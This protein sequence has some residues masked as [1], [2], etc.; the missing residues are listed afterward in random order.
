MADVFTQ[1]TEEDAENAAL[2]HY[3]DNSRLEVS[4]A[5]TRMI[6]YSLNEYEDEPVLAFIVK[7]SG[8]TNT[9]ES[10]DI[11]IDEDVI[12]SGYDL[13]VIRVMS[14]ITTWNDSHQVSGYTNMPTVVK[15]WKDTFGRNSL[16]NKGM[17]VKLVTHERVENCRDNSF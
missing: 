8:I 12:V 10:G 4:S 3:A 16:N 6:V 17:A 1:Y 11:H 13:S 7:V 9:P 5:D 14:N 15:W 2:N